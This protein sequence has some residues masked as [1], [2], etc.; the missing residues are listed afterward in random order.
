MSSLVLTND[1]QTAYQEF[2]KFIVSKKEDIFVLKGYAGTGK[3]ALVKH[4]RESLPNI[5][6]TR[7]LLTGSD[8]QFDVAITATTHKAAQALSQEIEY[9]V[10]TIH[11]LLA[12]TVVFDQKTRKNTLRPRTGTENILI[13]NHI[14][15]IDEASF[16]GHVLLSWIR[17]RTNKCK[18]VFIGDP[19][20]LLDVGSTYSPVFS[21]PMPGAEMKQIVR[22]KEDSPIAHLAAK[23]RDVLET[24]EFFS[25]VP[26]GKVIQH[27]PRDEFNACL[28][29]EFLRKDWDYEESKVLTWTNKG[30]IAYNN[31]LTNELTGTP[32]FKKGDYAVVNKYIR[33]KGGIFVNEQIV[34]ITECTPYTCEGIDGFKILLDNKA[35]VFF[36]KEWRSEAQVLRYL[37][38]RY[39][40]NSVQTNSKIENFMHLYADL[41]AA[42]ACTINKSQG[43][44][45]DRVFIDLDDVSKCKNGSQLAR[46]LYVAVSRARS[47]VVF[48]GDLV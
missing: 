2:V 46:L 8:Q 40:N 22:Q 47:G 10:V 13:E 20:Q 41:R 25:F 31:A 29:K 38:E 28:S 19:A 43:S 33:S 14:I 32:L 48:T 27:L 24:N 5:F 23:F 37:T 9:P 6:K 36:P 12:L 45:Y 34:H 15:F 21:V 4:L 3:T 42:F 1:Q 35:T 26:D 17:T 30:A 39:N 11:S 7:K 16:I 44:T 18:L